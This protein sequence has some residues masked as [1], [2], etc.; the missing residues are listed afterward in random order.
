MERPARVAL[1]NTG[2][3]G[4]LATFARCCRALA[5]VVRDPA[6][7]RAQ[8]AASAAGSSRTTTPFEVGQL[9]MSATLSSGTR[10][11]VSG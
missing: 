5:T 9:L 4:I 2:T 3:G 8:A 7:E 11:F 10:T 6:G 1:R